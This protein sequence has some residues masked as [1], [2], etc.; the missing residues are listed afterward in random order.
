MRGIVNTFLYNAGMNS[1]KV[2]IVHDYLVQYGGAEATLEYIC[3]IFPNAPIYTSVYNPKN[4]SEKLNSK[5]IITPKMS[6]LFNILPKHLTFLMPIVFENFDLSE[7]NIIISSGTAYAKSVL[8]KPD[9]LHIAYIHTPPRFLY[10]YS[11]ESTNR[12]KWYYKPIISYMDHYLKIW[13]YVAAQ[14]PNF[15]VTN[16]YNTKKR[17]EKFYNRIAEVIYPPIKLNDMYGRIIIHPNKDPLKVPYYFMHGRLSAYK[18]LDFVISAFNL[19]DIPLVI[20]GTGSEETK[21]KRMAGKN[22]TFLGRTSEEQKNT[23][24][25]NCL[26]FIF[27]VVEED[28]GMVVVEAMSHGK[29]VLAHKSGGARE[30]MRENIDGMFFENLSLDEFINKVKIFDEKIRRNEFNPAEIKKQTLKFDEKNFVSGF[31][32]FVY[33]KWGIHNA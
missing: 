11:V 5:R 22:V 32:N 26:G 7:F 15:I 12:S 19:L 18:N 2:A 23:Y 30:I 29:P 8:T 6:S 21:L 10:G 4:L 25:N 13:D 16:S 1:P 9:Q 28:F 14:R 31:K 3:D 24:Y 33:E 20:S 17:I 27:P